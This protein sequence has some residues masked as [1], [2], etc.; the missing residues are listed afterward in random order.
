LL[1]PETR[2]AYWIY[3]CATKYAL[4]GLMPVNGFV[5]AVRGAGFSIDVCEAAHIEATHAYH[6]ALKLARTLAYLAMAE[7]IGPSHLA[8]ALQYRPRLMDAG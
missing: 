7:N 1:N 2:L 4:L 6:R 3:R 5:E 8:E